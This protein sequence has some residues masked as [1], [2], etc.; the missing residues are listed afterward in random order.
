MSKARI[1]AD[2]VS[3]GDELA[4][5]AP[6]A[7]PAFTGTPTGITAA[8]ITSGVLPVGVTGGS[9]IK[10]SILQVKTIQT[11]QMYST[12]VSPDLSSVSGTAAYELAAL[13]MTMTVAS[14]SSVLITGS[15]CLGH[16]HSFTGRCYITYDHSG[17]SE[18]PI[19]SSIN[20]YSSTFQ[21]SQGGSEVA[22]QQAPSAVNLMFSPATANELTIKTRIMT[23]SSGEISYLNRTYDNH[24]N[25]N[26]GGQ[27]ISSLTFWEIGNVISPRLINNDIT[28]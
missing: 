23:S 11:G 9:G 18:T 4:L 17:I 5:K 26:D 19:V 14:T 15:L 1:L 24:T 3:S 21:F 22:V 10:G 7:S 8:H 28:T 16:R 2:Y 12:D 13:T 6:L 20:G 25:A 27:S